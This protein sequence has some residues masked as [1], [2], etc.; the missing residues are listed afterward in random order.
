MGRPDGLYADP[1]EAED[2]GDDPAAVARVGPRRADLERDAV[3][4]HQQGVLRPFFPAVHG[5][6]PAA[7]PPPKAR[8][9]TL[10]TAAVP[11]SSLSASQKAEQVGV[12]PVPGAEFLPPAQ[13]AVGGPP[14]AAEPG[15][16]VGPTVAHSRDE[17]D[18][19][20]HDPVGGAGPA[21][22]DIGGLFGRRVVADDLVEP[23]GHV[24]GR[25]GWNP[26]GA[27][28]REKAHVACRMEVSSQ[29]LKMHIDGSGA[30][31]DLVDTSG[32]FL[33]QGNHKVDVT[34]KNKATAPANNSCWMAIAAKIVS[35]APT[36]KEAVHYGTSLNDDKDEVTVTY[37]K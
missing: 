35:A 30:G 3:P 33:V 21:A 18:D 13:P 36:P 4:V 11:G 7:S 37:K 16:R 25:H 24:R 29:P 14:G 22:A 23:V 1:G 32:T 26:P 19:P 5:A 8:T 10:S 27:D 12:Q 28:G 20:H 2:G 17:P 9:T 15:G 6:R 31:K 34:Y